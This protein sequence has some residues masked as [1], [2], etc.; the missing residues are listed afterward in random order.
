MAVQRWNFRSNKLNSKLCN[1][2]KKANYIVHTSYT[3]NPHPM[4]AIHIHAYC[5]LSYVFYSQKLVNELQLIMASKRAFANHIQKFPWTMRPALPKLHRHVCSQ[6]LRSIPHAEIEAN[7]TVVRCAA[8]ILYM[9]ANFKN[10]FIIDFYQLIVMCLKSQMENILSQ[11]E[12][13]WLGGYCQ[14]FINWM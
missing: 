1:E 6:S 12:R 2:W 14:L 7:E 11:L 9:I 3:L 4:Y 13:L 10:S 5:V 8:P